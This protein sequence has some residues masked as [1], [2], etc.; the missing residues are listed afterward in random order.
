MSDSVISVFVTMQ[1]PVEVPSST[2]VVTV[3]KIA[4]TIILSFRCYMADRL[5]SLNALLR[6]EMFAVT[7]KINLNNTRFCDLVV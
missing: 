7:H 2:A 4:D 3:D 1:Q 6:G 5:M